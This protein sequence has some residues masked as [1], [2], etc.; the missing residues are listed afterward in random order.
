LSQDPIGRLKLAVQWMWSLGDYTRVA[1]L[2]VPGAV[3]LADAIPISPGQSV[4]DV[5]AGNGNFALVAAR[6][7][8]KVT[9]SDL[10][11]RMVELGRARSAAEGRSIEWVEADAE[12]LPFADS[13][14]DVV[15]SVFGAQFAPRPEV[16]AS[17]LVRIAGPRGTVAL[18]AYG[19]GF[20]SRYADLLGALSGPA[21]VKLPSPFEW[22]D[23]AEARR[24]L[25]AHS[26]SVSI[27][28]RDLVLEFESVD[29]C[30]DFW[31]ATNAPTIALKNMAPPEAYA[32]LMRRARAL[33]DELNEG[34]VGRVV[35]TNRYVIAVAS[36]GRSRPAPRR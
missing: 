34:R 30:I 8:A 7:G 6:R 28:E 32:E 33:I 20:L 31:A 25:G 35:L 5:A 29:D 14:F 19:K 21:P 24:R 1:R 9:A 10:T 16:V 17:E 11:P 23:P 22:G 4:L 18:A 27:D 13:S 2:L 36:S 3:A 26:S 12:S 15:A